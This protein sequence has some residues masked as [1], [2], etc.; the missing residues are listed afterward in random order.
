MYSFTAR[1]RMLPDFEAMCTFNQTSPESHFTQE[2]IGT[3][4]T[5][6]GRV[7][8]SDE[9]LTITDRSSKRKIKVLS[10][11]DF[12][13]KLRGHFGVHLS[14]SKLRNHISNLINLRLQ[15]KRQNEDHHYFS[16]SRL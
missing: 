2:V 15:K 7:S 9:L 5:K 4:A 3:I 8:L 14:Y 6:N 12:K 1:P 11:E 10:D 13:Q 16:C